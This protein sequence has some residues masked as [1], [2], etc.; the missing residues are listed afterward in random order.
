MVIK[1]SLNKDYDRNME[2]RENEKFCIFAPLHA[3]LNQYE[4]NRIKRNIM[5][6]ERMVAIDLNYVEECSIDFINTVKEICAE[7]SIGIFNIP[8]DIFTLFNVMQI[9]KVAQLFV[10]ELDFKSEQRQLINRCFKVV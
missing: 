6:E 8:S 10:S 7:K 2:I 4:S 3:K 5:K 1:I 9:D